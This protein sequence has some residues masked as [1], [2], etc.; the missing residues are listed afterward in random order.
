[1]QLI[2]WLLINETY[3][4]DNL[5]SEKACFE[6]YLRDLIF[7][8]SCEDSRKNAIKLSPHLLSYS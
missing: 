4:F 7:W 8:K 1:M 3:F 5:F 6:L 2:N